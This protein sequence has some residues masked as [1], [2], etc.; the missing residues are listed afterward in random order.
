MK[1]NVIEKRSLYFLISGILLVLSLLILAF[2]KLN[3]WIDMTWW[4][5]AEYSYTNSLDIEK[6]RTNLNIEA[7]KILNNKKE[8]IND[9]NAYKIS[10]E[11]KI[12]VTTWFNKV[13]LAKKSWETDA[14][15]S[16]RE[17]VKLEESKK[18]FRKIILETLKKQDKSV[19]ETSYTNIGKSFWDYIKDTAILTLIIA[20][21]AIAFYV[22]WAF[23][24]VASGISVLSFSAITIITLIHDVLISTWL[25]LF[26]SM[27]FPEFKV[28]TFFITAL[29]TILGYSINDTIVVFDRIRS[30]LKKLIKKENLKDIIDLSI[31]ETL[32]RSIF[33]SLTLFFVL[34]TI[35][36]F[37]P[38]SIKGFVL[39]M[40]FGTLI[41]TYSS[42]FIASPLLYEMNKKKKISEY[43]DPSLT[44]EDKIVV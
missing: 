35:F 42:I 36:L 23:S 4:T 26:A 1:L 18:E 34:L 27:Y 31:N 7:K 43:K 13:E 28:D 10:W 44:P 19:E 14:E 9:I 38:E 22:T 32:R 16:K 8:L 21:A 24:W 12:S 25:F 11:N 20:V 17:N 37:W 33:T 5:S 6:A 41:G 15:L 30:N 40:M 2:W 39:V 29:L 3:L